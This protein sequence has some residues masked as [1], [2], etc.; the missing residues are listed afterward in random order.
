MPTRVRSHAKINLGLAI[1]P[2]RPDGFHALL[3]L[4]QTLAVHDFVT[5]AARPAATTA[6]TLTSNHPRVPLD[7]RNTVWKMVERALLAADIT[8]RRPS[9]PPEKHLPIQG[10]MGAGSANAAAALL[11]LEHELNLHLP[12]ETRLRIAAEVGSDVPLF[13]LGGA[14]L[15]TDRGQISH[16]PS[17]PHPR[18]AS[19]RIPCVVA[20]PRLG[21]STPAAFRDWDK[22]LRPP[23]NLTNL[24]S[25]PIGDTMEQLS[26]TYA[27]VFPQASG[28]QGIQTSR[29]RRLRYLSRIGFWS[30]SLQEHP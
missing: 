17:R 14:V 13:L 24:Q 18:P 26:R 16:S 7:A 30:F 3:T 8:R 22:P 23:S 29:V 21:V 4:Y 12:D 27:S 11:G 28:L 20:L 25:E 15:G 10:G 5:V 1:G 6:I 19:E 2:P 9:P